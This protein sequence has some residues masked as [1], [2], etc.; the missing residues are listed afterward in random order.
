MVNNGVSDHTMIR[1]DLIITPL[2]HD[3]W[4]MMVCNRIGCGV[5]WFWQRKKQSII[6]HLDTWH[7]QLGSGAPKPWLEMLWSLW[8]AAMARS[9]KAEVALAEPTPNSK[10]WSAHPKENA[11]FSLL[12]VQRLGRNLARRR[13]LLHWGTGRVPTRRQV[14]IAA[15]GP[16][17]NLTW[18]C[19]GS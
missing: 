18:N 13:Q 15:I 7:C 9:C 19:T 10:P 14:C 16:C 2:T 1:I 6:N 8:A 11:P 17:K 4:N 5:Y 12:V 3:Y